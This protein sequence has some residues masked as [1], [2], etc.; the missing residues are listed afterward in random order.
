VTRSRALP[1]AIVLTLALAAAILM[2]GASA[3]GIF[4]PFVYAKETPSWAAQ[5]MGQDVVNLIVVLPAVAICIAHG[6]RGSL[7]AVLVLLG[8]LF[9]MIYSYVLYAFFVHF[10]ALFPIYVAVLGLSFYALVGMLMEMDSIAVRS[11]FA[12]KRGRAASAYLMASGVAFAILWLAS[13]ASAI[14]AGGTPPDVIEAGLPVNP[15]HVLDLAFVL[16]GMIVT[17]VLLW[18]RRPFGF[19]LA[20]PLTTFAAAMCLAIVGMM[21]FMRTRGLPAPAALIA[22]LVVV[23]GL[24][25]ALTIDLLRPSVGGAGNPAPALESAA[26][27]R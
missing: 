23:S 19:L 20:V 1:G 6:A 25:V 21:L 11:L 2:G 14:A 27:P 12:A 3:A 7:R 9:Y 10:N 5:G 15:V 17:S 24:A 8:L 26:F 16:P 4:L 18:R 13:I 22:G